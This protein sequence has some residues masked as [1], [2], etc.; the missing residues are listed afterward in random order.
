MART[1]PVPNFAAIPGMNPGIFVLGGGGDGGGS[2]AGGGKGGKGKQGAGGK[3]GGKDAKG[4]GKNAPDYKKYPE[5]G[6]ESHP[7]DVV[8]GRAFTHPIADLS[9]PGPLPLE[10]CRM[11][12]SAMAELDV[13]LGFGW[14]HTLGWEIEERR[15]HVVVRNEQGVA[16]HFPRIEVG[17]Q[18]VGPW[19]WALRRETWGYTLDADDQRWR[20]F[21]LRDDVEQVYKLSAISDVHGNTIALEY[22]GT[23]LAGITDSAGRKIRF[24]KTPEGRIFAVDVLDTTGGQPVWVSFVEYSYNSVGDLVRV[25]DADG[26]A[27][28]YAYDD[29]HRLTR[30]TDRVGLSFCFRYDDEGRCIESWGEYG[31]R[32]DPS[33]GKRPL[34]ATLADGLTP[35]RGIH[36][37]KVTYGPDGFTE[38]ADFTE[39]RRYFGNDLGTLDKRVTAAG[40]ITASY[41][42]NG[43]LRSRTDERGGTVT[44]ERDARGRLTRLVDA[45]GRTCV[46]ER[47]ALGLMTK[48]VTPAGGERT[49]ARDARGNILMAR[50][51]LG[52]SSSL[53]YDA[54]GFV[55]E[56]IDAAGRKTTFTHDA[57]GNLAS[58]TWWNGATW[59]YTYDAFGRLLSETEPHGATTRLSYSRRGDVLRIVDPAGHATDMTYDGEEQLL[60]VVSPGGRTTELEWG[61]YHELCAIRDNAGRFVQIVYGPDG[62]VLEIVN[63]VGEEHRY[64]NSADGTVVHQ[65]SF[66]GVTTSYVY[67]QGDLLQSQDHLGRKTIMVYN[68]VGEMVARELHDGSKE[69]LEYDDLGLVVRAKRGD[70][71][72]RV[73]RDIA[74]RVI[75]E[76]QI[77]R[78]VPISIDHERDAVGHRRARK[79]SLGHEDRRWFDAAGSETIELGPADTVL[80]QKELFGREVAR[81]LP[82]GGRI[83]TSFDATGRLTGKR[84]VRSD[85]MRSVYGHEPAFLGARDE[86]VTAGWQY[87][88]G[89]DG[90]IQEVV[91]H[92]GKSRQY[93]HDPVGRL[94]AVVAGELRQEL[95]RFDPLGNVSAAREGEGG[96]TF[97]PG[98]RLLRRGPV[99]YAYDD[100]GQLVEKRVSAP[101]GEEV[102]HY[103]WDAE[104]LLSEVRAPDGTRV[105]ML[106]DAFDRRVE[107]RVSPP[108]GAGDTERTSTRFV[109]DGDVLVHEIKVCSGRAGDPVIEERTYCF[110]RDSFTPLAHRVARVTGEVRE[111][112]DWYYYVT[113]PAGTPERLVSGDGEIACELQRSAWGRTTAL[114]GA[115]TSTPWRFSGQYEDEETGLCYNRFRYYDPDAARYISP[116]PI[117][118][119]GGINMYAYVDNPTAQVDP[120]GLAGACTCT[121]KLKQPVGGKDEYTAKSGNRKGGKPHNDVVQKAIDKSKKPTKPRDSAQKNGNTKGKCAEPNALS[122]Y[123]NA[124]EQEKGVS[125]ANNPE[126]LKDAVDNIE[127]YDA[128]DTDT[129]TRKR[130]CNWCRKVLPKVS[131]DLMG[132]AKNR[133]GPYG[134]TP[135]SYMQ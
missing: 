133:K 106:Y 31:D 77:V 38:A 2:G 51:E 29:E 32:A 57:Q 39:I 111:A 64:T 3:N 102:W 9:L 103:D 34:P 83:D 105:E 121:I 59:R 81:H 24:R 93:K 110:E 127:S 91:S 69:E 84:V 96:T 28:H 72:T 21:G 63:E 15:R 82:R 7:I 104:G 10:F 53:Q 60:R 95:Y 65:V 46:I 70:V 33:L 75:R 68:I 80:L 76:T 123:F 61:G 16:T 48:F 113:D 50:N 129:N 114:P 43:H 87:R 1:A 12:S 6:F 36:H 26:H 85:R 125:L 131:K 118:V 45:L 86:D 11:Y 4:G 90:E 119:E 122:D 52:A 71:E 128:V 134:G 109:Y 124:Y 55:T 115:R 23:A 42:D 117:G 8:T 25:T 99:S 89:P 54:R 98:N 116:D 30:D 44:Y 73:E 130:M 62:S 14:A 100:L 74:G 108:A 49:F 79:T 107:K 22:D 101:H 20:T 78:G 132:K 27:W 97:G 112:G 92:T 41:F 66:D 58:K 40:V 126:A 94:V 56:M 19:G 5:C 67:R 13:G 17:E 18:V 120:L 47:D 88:Y 135:A 37:V 35:A